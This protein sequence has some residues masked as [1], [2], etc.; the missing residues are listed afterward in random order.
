MMCLSYNKLRDNDTGTKCSKRMDHNE[1][2][3]QKEGN[4]KR[5]AVNA[6]SVIPQVACLF[7]CPCNRLESMMRSKDTKVYQL[8]FIYTHPSSKP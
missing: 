7:L 2:A 8:S 4:T 3:N 6:T 1:G 5:V